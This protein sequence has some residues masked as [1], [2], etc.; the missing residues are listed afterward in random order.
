LRNTKDAEARRI[1]AKF[2]SQGLLLKRDALEAIFQQHREHN[3]LEKLIEEVIKRVREEGSLFVEQRHV[4]EVIKAGRGVAYEKQQETGQAGFA[5]RPLAKDVEEDVKVVFEAKGNFEIHDDLG[6]R[7]KYFRERLRLIGETMRRRLDLSGLVSLSQAY[8][9]D[10][11]EK[12]RVVVLVL[13]KRNSSF[14][15]EDQTAQGRVNIPKNASSE[16]KKKFNNLVPDV[17]VGLWV[18]KFRGALFCEDIIYPDVPDSP[19]NRS[20]QR[21][22]AVLTSDLHVGSK[23]FMSK[24]FKVFLRWLKGELGDSASIE[25][26]S[27]VKYLLI[28]GDLVDGIGI[29]PDQDKELELRTSYEQYKRVA[30]LLSEVPEYVRVIV[31]PGN[32]DFTRKALPQPPIAEENAQPVLE[33]GNVLSLANPALISL[34]GVYFQMFHG[35]SL[36]DLASLV[37]SARRE[38]PQNMMQYL[39]S[40]RH[41][42][43]FYGG[44]TEM[45]ALGSD[46]LVMLEKPDVFHAGH[47]H[48]FGAKIYRGVSIVNTGT[49]QMTT[50]YQQMMGVEPTP[51]IFAVYHLDAATLNRV[52]LGELP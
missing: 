24:G 50:P 1:A 16:L 20:K 15:V 6:S 23:Y 39:L 25:T 21:L 12:A 46:E 8:A 37:P 44:K 9:M 22:A 13:E 18:S 2:S 7:V 49:W 17:V 48:I 14:Y 40:V 10:D 32:H 19:P 26:A 51:G 28:A 31:I 34:H 30:E 33:L 41:L 35:Q 36:E 4:L 38:E 47:V 45:Q 27:K 5:F 29:Y 43:P 3:E 11:G 42:A 52:H